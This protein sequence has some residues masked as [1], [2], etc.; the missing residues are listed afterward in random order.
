MGAFPASFIKKKIETDS[1]IIKARQ[2]RY[3]AKE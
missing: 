1:S 2:H 3:Y